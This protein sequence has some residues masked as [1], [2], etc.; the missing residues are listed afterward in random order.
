MHCEWQ[1]CVRVCACTC[2]CPYMSYYMYVHRPAPAVPYHKNGSEKGKVEKPDENSES[3][4]M[5][6]SLNSSA[7]SLTTGSLTS[8]KSFHSSMDGHSLSSPP[9]ATDI[10]LYEDV[11]G[12]PDTLSGINIISPTRES[13]T[14]KEHP[15]ST[16]QRML[17]TSESVPSF[18]SHKAPNKMSGKK[19]GGFKRFLSRHSKKKDTSQSGKY[20]Y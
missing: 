2:V 19:R 14:E 11:D 3:D 15:L 8:T 12:V 9:S 4:L 17:V 6:G 5:M 20:M 1:V 16:P 13:S 18:G 7:N 10:F